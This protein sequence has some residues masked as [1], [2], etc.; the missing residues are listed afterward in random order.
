[1]DDYESDEEDE[2]DNVEDCSCEVD[3]WSFDD[4]DDVDM[5]EYANGLSLW[6]ELGEDFE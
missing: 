5:S 6:D 4:M 3:D 2:P 1:M